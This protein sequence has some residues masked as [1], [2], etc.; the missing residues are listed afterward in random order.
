MNQNNDALPDDPFA[1]EEDIRSIE[2]LIREDQEAERE[3]DEILNNERNE[4]RTK[5]IVLSVAGV[6]A[7]CSIA[8]AG[9]MFNPFDNDQKVGTGEITSSGPS[10]NGGDDSITNA[11]D[12]NNADLAEEVDDF[13]LDEGK[14]FPTEVEEWAQSEYTDENVSE[15]SEPVLETA[16]TE[17][18]GEASMLLPSEEVGYTSD[19][20]KKRTEDGSINLY[21]T[22]WTM[23]DFQK[24]STIAIERLI[25]PTFGGW[26]VY[27]YPAYKANTEYDQ[28][29]LNDLFTNNF[30]TKNEGKPYSEYMPI[31]ADWNSDNYGGQDNLLTAGPRWHGDIVSSET[32]FVYDSSISQYVVNLTADV[33]F[34]AWGQDQSILEKN[35]VLTIKFVANANEEGASSHKVLIDDAS[36]KVE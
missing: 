35:G 11:P 6:L 28:R 12:D 30:L 18:W 23:E 21:Y 16:K 2:D 8:V 34:T 7:V 1:E 14:Y 26:G 3:E 33:K 5:K 31:Y 22:Y 25:N 32:E 27:Q 36:L 4:G 13:Y 19:E 29:I 20:N 9:V 17:E 24:E 15:I 10:D